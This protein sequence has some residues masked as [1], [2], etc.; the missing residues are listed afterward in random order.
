M[1]SFSSWEP[2]PG[3]SAANAETATAP[4]TANSAIPRRRYAESVLLNIGPSGWV[5]PRSMKPRVYLLTIYRC[6]ASRQRERVKLVVACA[7]SWTEARVSR[8]PIHGVFNDTGA[9]VDRRTGWKIPQE[10]PVCRIQR[11]QSRRCGGRRSPHRAGVNDP[12]GYGHGTNVE[13]AVRIRGL[14]QDMSGRRIK[15]GPGASAPGCIG[16]PI[17][18]GYRYIDAR[19]I[20][21]LPPFHTPQRRTWAYLSCPQN[22]AGIRIESIVDPAFLPSAD[23]SFGSGGALVSD[24][25]WRRAE[26]VVWPTGK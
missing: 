26:I 15:R 12:I 2:F 6:S 1:L 9:G 8:S 23:D 20:R 7:E 14:P 11:K 16:D 10:F 24:F 25:V 22:S 21:R 17:E 4:T 19:P 3:C 18:I 5:H 13:G